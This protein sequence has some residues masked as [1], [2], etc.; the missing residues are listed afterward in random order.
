MQQAVRRAFSSWSAGVSILGA[1]LEKIKKKNKAPDADLVT[2]R[3]M[4]L[5]N[6]PSFAFIRHKSFKK[7]SVNSQDLWLAKDNRFL[8]P[9]FS[10]KRF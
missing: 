2:R 7:S 8:N 9:K 5:K 3:P 6:R 4:G 1:Q 10:F